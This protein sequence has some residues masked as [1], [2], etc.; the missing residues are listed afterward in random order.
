[1]QR[2]ARLTSSRRSQAA[3]SPGRRPQA[4]P[5]SLPA[6]QLTCQQPE[7]QEPLPAA[8]PREAE[9]E[10]CRRVFRHRRRAPERAQQRR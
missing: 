10:Y 1:M 5:E 8:E 9:E 3:W 2:L 4:Q 7:P 6:E